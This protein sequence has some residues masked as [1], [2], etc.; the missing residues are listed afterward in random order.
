MKLSTRQKHENKPEIENEHKQAPSG[1]SLDLTDGVIWK[2]LAA[3]TLPILCSS[4]FQ[5]LYVTVSS[6]VLGVYCGSQAVAAVGST[7]SLINLTIGLFMGISSGASVCIARHWGAKNE[8]VS[9]A[10]NTAFV[11]SL[12]CGIM[13]TVLGIAVCRPLLVLMKFPPELIDMSAK[14]LTI[15]FTGMVP[16]MVYNIGAGILRA[17]GDSRRPLIYLVISGVINVI[18]TFILVAGFDMGVA[19]AALATVISLTAS[20]ILTAARLFLTG[21]GYGVSFKKLCLDGP[22]VKEIIRIGIPVGMQ[23]ILYAITNMMIQANINVFGADA[24]AGAAAYYK[25]D[26]FQYLPINA[27]S[28]AMMTFTAQNL[29]ANRFDR[30][31]RGIRSALIMG[32]GCSL[33]AGTLWVVLGRHLLLLLTGGSEAAV[34]YGYTMLLCMATLEWTFVPTEVLGGVIRGAGATLMSAL[35]TAIFICGVRIVILSVL[36]PM[37]NNIILVF[38]TYPISWSICSTAFIIYYKKG[39]W[40]YRRHR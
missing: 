38:L 17:V 14:Y 12:I 5:Q 9:P 23:S 21:Y 32:F 13:L 7:N 22:I 36:M 26:G 3:F 20:A 2:T 8:K 40:M 6:A 34:C 10:V 24:M 37:V 31:R 30:V 29:G 33:F 18:F 16:S 25:L 4:L 27:I 35:L 19:G 39:H 1:A 15:Y 28:I 11:L